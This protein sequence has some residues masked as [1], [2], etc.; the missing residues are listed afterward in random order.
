MALR[1]QGLEK[2]Y[3]LANNPIFVSM[4]E[5]RPMDYYSIRIGIYNNI[6]VTPKG[7]IIG[8][9]NP[10]TSI[11]ISSYIKS[12]F[13][14]LKHNNNVL[15]VEINI[16]AIKRE[17]NFESIVSSITLNKFFVFGGKR[18]NESNLTL[19]SGQQLKL[20]EKIPYWRGYENSLS[21]LHVTPTMSELNHIDIDVTPHE[22]F[23]EQKKIKGCNSVYVKFLNSLGGYSYWLFEGLTDQ[24][25][26]EHLGTINNS[27]VIDFGNNYER[28]IEL[29]SKVSRAYLP[30][31]QDLIISPEIYIYRLGEGGIVWD[32]HYAGNNTIDVNPAK[33]AQEVKVKLK[34]FS[35]FK[36][37]L[38]W[39]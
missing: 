5:I 33:S 10:W 6:I 24:Q 8:L 37:A 27:K 39:Q 22:S 32:R 9:I 11:N 15:K 4:N 26:N 36:P 16:R 30:I 20:T 38:I 13:P 34:P 29:Y 19:Q 35:R 17:L 28:E 18:T 23:V 25:K 1:V 2:D 14:E 12:L 31:I 21:F 3:Y 7:L